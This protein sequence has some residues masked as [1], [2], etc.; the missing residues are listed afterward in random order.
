[1]AASELMGIVRLVI[2]DI[3]NQGALDLADLCF[4]PDYINHGG[5]IPDLVCGP[6]AI[7]ISVALY[8]LAFPF[9]QITIDDLA[10]EGET[11]ILRWTAHATSTENGGSIDAES[12]Q[13]A[14]V[15]VTYCR[16]VERQIAESWT[17]WDAEGESGQLNLVPQL[18]ERRAGTSSDDGVSGFVA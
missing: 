7:K 5:L 16:T 13:R 11:V 15:G 3:W 10:T 18:L 6:E 9:F 14:L 17:Y 12:D 1:M 2:E 8:R 4:A